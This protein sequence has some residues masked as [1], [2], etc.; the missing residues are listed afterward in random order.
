MQTMTPPDSPSPSESE[1]LPPPDPEVRAKSQR[2]RYTA[3]YKRRIVE[4]VNACSDRSEVGAL[5]RREG[6]YSSLLSQWRRQ[7]KED[8]IDGLKPK[9]RGPK[10]KHSTPE[11]KRIAE[12]EQ[13]VRQLE[14]GKA[15]VEAKL[16]R[17]DLMLDLQK[18]VSEILGVPLAAPPESDS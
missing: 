10:P 15:R 4:E 11:Q 18:K 6:L 2:R 1:G 3:E 9:K 14:R 8:P 16:K 7:A 13:Q 12:L 17:A 5:L